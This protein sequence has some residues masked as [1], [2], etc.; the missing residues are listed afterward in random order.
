MSQPEDRSL[1]QPCKDGSLV[2]T[3]VNTH[4]QRNADNGRLEV[5][6]VTRNI[7]RRRATEEQL[8]LS[9]QR[10]RL[11]AEHARDVLWTMA[12][13]GRITYVSPAVEKVRGITPEEAMAQPFTEIHPPASLAVSVGYFQQLLDDAQAGRKPKNFRGEL[14]YRCKDGSTYW[15]EVFVYPVLNDAG[16]LVEIVGVSR[17]IDEHKRF[18]RDLQQA[19]EVTEAANRALQ[20]ANAELQRI[21]TTDALTGVWNRRHFEQALQVEVARTARHGSPLSLLL[22]DLDH[23][24]VVN[25]VFG[26]QVGDVVLVQM[27]DLSRQQLRTGDVLARWGGEEFV[28]LMP[29]C[30]AADAAVL[31]E[32]LRLNLAACPMPEVGNVTASD[33]VAQWGSRANPPMSGSSGCTPPCMAPRKVAATG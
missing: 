7:T 4:F 5:F 20:E 13:D 28:V 1:Q 24:K 6:G 3:E 9:E 27:A 2:W 33:G 10:H 16:Q 31:A 25:D 17:D 14:E 12:P 15:S 30:E 32:R 19:K 21:A 11:L 26:H 23:F 18:A 22:L 8:R 29:E